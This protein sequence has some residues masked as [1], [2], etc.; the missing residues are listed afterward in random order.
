MDLSYTSNRSPDTTLSY[1]YSSIRCLAI[2]QYSS[3]IS[4]PIQYLLLPSVDKGTQT[5]YKSRSRAYKRVKYNTVMIGKSQNQ[6]V[7]QIRRKLAWM[8]GSFLGRT[9]VSCGHF[10]YFPYIGRIFPQCIDTQPAIFW[11]WDILHFYP[12]WH[13]NEMYIPLDFSH[14][15]IFFHSAGSNSFYRQLQPNNSIQFPDS[16]K[17]VFYPTINKEWELHAHDFPRE[18]TPGSA[19]ER[20]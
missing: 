12:V 19:T 13:P 11:N 16:G 14:T 7:N 10:R 20:H 5:R 3:F 1:R 4:K 18:H 8:R 2:A 9:L 15:T 17:E 6:P